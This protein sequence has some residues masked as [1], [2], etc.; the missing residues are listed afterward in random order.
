MKKTMEIIWIILVV[1]TLFA[2]GIGYLKYVNA[3]LVAIL[4]LT[5][6]I[7]AQLVIDYFMGLKNVQLKYRMIPIIWLG[8][9]LSLIAIAYYLP[10][11][12]SIQGS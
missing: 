1:L 12:D 10:V 9:T 4:L 5:T 3:S 7:K 2:F 6:F 11:A 8:V